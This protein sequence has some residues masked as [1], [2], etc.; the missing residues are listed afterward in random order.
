MEQFSQW[1]KSQSQHIIGT[2][3]KFKQFVKPENNFY[4]S[5]FLPDHI[6]LKFIKDLV[7]VEIKYKKNTTYN[8]I[9][10][11]LTSPLLPLT[12][13]C[14]IWFWMYSLSSLVCF[15]IVFHWA[16]PWMQSSG[17]K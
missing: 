12:D 13:Y 7:E 5:S 8:I 11:L 1:I 2:S 6:F 17:K 9:F 10:G 4:F 16:W 3:F 14:F 15:K